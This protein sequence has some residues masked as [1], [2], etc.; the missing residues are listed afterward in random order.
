MA[1]GQALV[2]ILQRVSLP[3]HRLP[4]VISCSVDQKAFRHGTAFGKVR[5]FVPTAGTIVPSVGTFVPT[6]KYRWHQGGF[7][8][9]LESPSLAVI[10]SRQPIFAASLALSMQAVTVS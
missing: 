8:P 4:T 6:V 1:A 2:T 10:S 3:W 5:T 9:L 7:F